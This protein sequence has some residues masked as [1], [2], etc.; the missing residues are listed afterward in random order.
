MKKLL[1]TTA[2]LLAFVGNMAAQ[3]V[4]AEIAPFK[5]DANGEA[6][7]SMT[8]TNSVNVYSFQFDLYLPEGVSLK[9]S[10]RGNITEP[11]S[12]AKDP[13][14]LETYSIQGSVH[15]GFYRFTAA[16][17]EEAGGNDGEIFQ[18]FVEASDQV[19]TG[20]QVAKL[21]GMVFSLSQNGG[22]GTGLEL[23]AYEVTVTPTI[24]VKVSSAGYATFS[25]PKTLDFSG[26]DGLAVYRA[27]KVEEGQLTTKLVE[28]GIVPA[29]EGVLLKGAAGTYNPETTDK[30]GT[31]GTNEFKGT[32]TETYTVNSTGIW[33]FANLDGDKG[34]F[35]VKSGVEIPMYKAYLQTTANV[36]GFL[37][38][39]E[40]DGI[41]DMQL[42]GRGELYNLS[43]QKVDGQQHKGIYIR[44]GK[45][46]VVK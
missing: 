40:T 41:R 11:T 25:W 16:S 23:P 10:K 18:F 38:D 13:D 5:I 39:S 28:D 35:P 2:C 3:T 30:T 19:S 26:C 1:L 21:D 14:R 37:L 44:D 36:R 31:F 15:N 12:Y 9:L 4:K 32:A 33:A 27:D 20:P 6:T 22:A 24:P 42:N 29:C 45:K 17:Y 43:G 34:F 46:F 7:L 8:L